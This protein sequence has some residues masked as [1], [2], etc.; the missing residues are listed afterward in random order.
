MKRIVSR[1]L[2]VV[3][4]ALV[5][6]DWATKFWIVN[7]MAL[8]ETLSLVDGWLY[9]V[10]RQNTGV[11]F[12]MFAD[13]PEAWRVPL[14]S[15]LSLL[16][17]ALFGKILLSTA[18]RAVQGAAALVMAGAVGNLGDRLVNGHVTDFVLV[19]FFPFVFNF[20]DALITVG[21]ILLAYR[22]LTEEDALEPAPTAARTDAT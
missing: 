7:R 2:A 4:V 12:S 21:G 16:G 11:A 8:G 10:Y 9:F 14:L 3:V 17:V 1:S 15:G 13:L 18:D 19:R 6:A 5:L 22:L 20:A